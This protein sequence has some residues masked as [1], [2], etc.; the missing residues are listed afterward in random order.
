[1]F[2]YK[3]GNELSNE[4]NYCTRCGCKVI[5]KDTS[6]VFE[7]KTNNIKKKALKTID[8]IKRWAF[9]LA[10]LT[11]IIFLG[12][13]YI[14]DKKREIRIEQIRIIQ[15][16]YERLNFS[17]VIRL[18]EK[19]KDPEFIEIN[20]KSKLY[21]GCIE[22]INKL[23]YDSAYKCINESKYKNDQ[24]SKCFLKIINNDTKSFECAA[25]FSSGDDDINNLKTILWVTERYKGINTYLGTEEEPFVA[26]EYMDGDKVLIANKEVKTNYDDSGRVNSLRNMD[27]DSCCVKYQMNKLEE[28]TIPP[29]ICV[30]FNGDTLN[31]SASIETGRVI[32]VRTM[33]LEGYSVPIKSIEYDDK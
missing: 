17:E 5:K 19:S 9:L 28:N 32:D 24:M 7:S 18:T 14:I 2:C 26:F 12:G 30:E 13:Y 33:V 1:M 27:F 4:D 21:S 31:Y 16:E 8:F 20:N 15:N 6:Y 29:A 11:I 22:Y 23:D 3:C 25:S 10:V